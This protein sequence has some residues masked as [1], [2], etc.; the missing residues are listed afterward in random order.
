MDN[1][2]VN[3]QK[4][5]EFTLGSSVGVEKARWKVHSSE[6]EEAS[7]QLRPQASTKHGPKGR[8][9]RGR[10]RFGLGRQHFLV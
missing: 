1:S 9:G 8:E 6:H 5:N 2:W 10:M 7:G 3:N 4:D